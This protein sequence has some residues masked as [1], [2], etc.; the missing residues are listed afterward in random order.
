M[1]LFPDKLQGAALLEELVKSV[2][3]VISRKY[4]FYS[5]YV[6]LCLFSPFLNEMIQKMKKE[7]LLLETYNYKGKSI[8]MNGQK[9]IY[10]EKECFIS[11]PIIVVD[12]ESIDFAFM[13]KIDIKDIYA[14]A[15]YSYKN[16]FIRLI[17]FCD[18]Q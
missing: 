6:A 4:W 3:P 12:I 14:Q 7:K 18:E 13:N 11:E 8:I 15:Y 1:A 5:C 16:A 9:N 17:D 2:I 10:M